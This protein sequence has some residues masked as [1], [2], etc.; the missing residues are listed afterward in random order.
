M[1]HKDT[2]WKFWNWSD[3]FVNSAQLNGDAI[4]GANWDLIGHNEKEPTL[5]NFPVQTAGGEILRQTCCMVVEAGIRLC[6]PIHDAILVECEV[7]EID[8]TIDRTKR[9]MIEATRLVLSDGDVLQVGDISGDIRVDAEVYA[10]PIHFEGSQDS[11]VWKL[12]TRMRE[13]EG[14]A[15]I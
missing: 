5:R 6:A 4:S 8:R 14:H 11:A 10:H 13:E 12:I 1:L 15:P 9:V 7:G 3:D 2:F